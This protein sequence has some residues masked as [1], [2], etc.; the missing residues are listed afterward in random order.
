[1]SRVT[2]DPDHLLPDRDRLN[3]NSPVR[4]VV[5]S[6]ANVFPLDALVL[7]PDPTTGGIALTYLNR[8]RLSLGQDFATADLYQG[9]GEHLFAEGHLIESNLGGRVGITLTGFAQPSI[10]SP[11]TYWQ[12]AYSLTLAAYRVLSDDGA[13]TYAHLE[14]AALPVVS[15]SQS[16]TVA[17]DL[18]L[19]GAGRAEVTASDEAGVVPH[20][21]VQGTLDVGIGFGRVP[22]PLLFD[23]EEL[24]SFGQM[25]PVG[26][27]RTRFLG[28]EKLFGSVAIEFPVTGQEPF[29][30][31]NLLMLDRTRGRLFVAAG[32]TWSGPNG[33]RDA[34]PRV[35]VGG[36]GLFDL[37]AIGGL[38]TLQATLGYASPLGEGGAGVVYF[39]ISF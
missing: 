29:N 39:Q 24:H 18:S 28:T 16:A 13:L 20:V 37:S 25:T 34:T 38:L 10:G 6:G 19:D 23:L 26:W 4:F 30:V 36:E 22:T 32:M 5:T 9:R 3:N 33:W 7:R 27:V 12:P 31:G 8:V 35:E 2:I 1:V 15:S 11:G 21:Y 17:L 14:L